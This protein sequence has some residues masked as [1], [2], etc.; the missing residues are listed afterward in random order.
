MIQEM[1]SLMEE[2]VNHA[3]TSA[4]Q[5]ADVVESTNTMA[6]LSEDVEKILVDFKEELE[7]V[8]T[9]TG[10]I[11][12]ITAQTNLLAL[13]ASIEAARAEDAGGFMGIKDIQPGM[14]LILA[15]GNGLELT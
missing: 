8:K 14:R 1:V 12:A 4:K 9:E 13:N 10:T 3:N 2:S 6:E 11:E 5:L 7:M 15:E